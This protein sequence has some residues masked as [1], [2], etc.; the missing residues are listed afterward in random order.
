MKW[1]W[2]GLFTFLT[3]LVVS[4]A[5][6]RPDT[7]DSTLAFVGVFLSV[8]A[9]LALVG[10][11]GAVFIGG[12][13]YLYLL[14]RRSNVETLRQRDGHYPLQR[15]KLANGDYMFVDMNQAVGPALRV[16]R[17]TGE[18]HEPEP[19]AGWHVQ[20]TIRALVERTRQMQA[21]FQGDISRSTEYGSQHAGDRITAAAAKLAAGQYEPRTP[22]ITV[23]PSR[24]EPEPEP[25]SPVRTWTAREGLAGNSNMQF[26]MGQTA[27]GRLV[28]WRPPSGHLRVHGA[29]QGSG[30]TN[31]IQTLAAGAVRC[32]LHLIVLDRRKFK[33]WQ[34]FSGRAE[35]VD[36]R[37]PKVFAAAV[38]ALCALY[39]ERD[40]ALGRAGAPNIGYL[41]DPPKRVLVVVSEFGALCATAQADGVLD[42]VLHP[43][44]LVMRE[45]AATGVHVVI[46]DQV[47]DRRWPRGIS[48]NAEPVTGYLPL[49]YG[50]AGGYYDAHKLPPYQFHFAG[51]VFT[52]W[53]MQPEL[54]GL[55][56]A[57]SAPGPALLNLAVHS[58][59]QGSSQGVHGSSQASS[60]QF[61][62][63]FTASSQGSSP[64]VDP[65]LV[66]I[67]V[68]ATPETVDGWYEWTL[69]N[70][71]PAHPEL[72][73][74]DE[75]GRGL[76]VADLARAMAAENGK[77]WEV[78]KGMASGV[79]KRLRT[80]VGF[81][82]GTGEVFTT[83]D[84]GGKKDKH[85]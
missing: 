23:S 85:G 53:H 24:P 30:K 84:T 68:N 15:V 38:R 3:F 32:G 76:G 43:L 36:A 10:A 29:T 27:T 44:T 8:T 51:A 45:A 49:N 9:W 65:P 16:N 67:S 69:D 18:V 72:L 50:S 31:L 64:E 61:T 71:L 22:A 54:R 77:D 40:E 47:V 34:E 35:L 57:A 14:W 60:Q 26:V 75:R 58:S 46:E 42:Q 37:D 62:D 6:V 79:A 63:Q 17:Q 83:D 81:V 82:G 2:L 66:N 7:V 20:A 73:Q 78:M 80:E 12:A 48:A 11:A 13:L 28:Y 4:A 21:M 25:P 56:A 5:A 1:F 55:L 52:T 74:V 39:Q 41:P 70:Y 19:A 33:D 59:S